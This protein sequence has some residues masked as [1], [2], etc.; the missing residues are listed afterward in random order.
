VNLMP[1]AESEADSSV[2]ELLESR[3]SRD[4]AVRLLR[5]V[6]MVSPRQLSR[7]GIQTNG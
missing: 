2:L 4:V 6:N 1:D 5:V 7:P 3:L